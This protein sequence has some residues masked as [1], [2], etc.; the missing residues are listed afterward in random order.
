MRIVFMGTGE[1]GLPTLH[2]LIG[3]SGHEI[4]GLFT[5]PDK[6]VGRKQILT[7]PEVKNVAEAAD[8]PV[9]Q[10]HKLSHNET[11]FDFLRELEAD[12]FV[13]MA[14]GQILPTSIIELPKLACVNLHASLLPRHRGASPIQAAIREGDPET[15]ITL[16]HIVRELDAGD[17]IHKE[18]IP[19]SPD[20][21]GGSLHDK[22]A[23]LG[24][25]TLQ[26]GFEKIGVERESQDES[27][28]TYAPKLGREDGEI[29]WQKPAVEIERLIRAYDPWPG[30]IAMLDGARIKIYPY[31]KSGPD[32]DRQ[33]GEVFFPSEKS[34][35]AVACG[36]GTSLFFGG[37]S[38]FQLDGRKRLPVPDFLRGNLIAE[39]ARFS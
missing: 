1:I 26:N 23:E 3:Q 17:M 2:F 13:V 28:V 19:I 9:F 33:P 37:K 38:A 30:T 6:K 25:A 15:G 32:T 24:P 16:M 31:A 4:A 21:T 12:L 36:E 10:P 11:T 14:Y 39:G 18:T 7:P 35:P 22:L 29:D 34:E 27:L 20:D 5:Q 8:I